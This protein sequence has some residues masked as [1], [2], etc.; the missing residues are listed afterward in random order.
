MSYQDYL[1][2]MNQELMDD[3]FGRGPG[4]PDAY[5]YPGQ[6]DSDG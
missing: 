6:D 4:D 1:D 3:L 5:G 2:R